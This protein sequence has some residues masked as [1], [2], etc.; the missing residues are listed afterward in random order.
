MN[1]I[2]SRVVDR[3]MVLDANEKERFLWE[4]GSDRCRSLLPKVVQALELR[5]RVTILVTVKTSLAL[6]HRVV[7]HPP[8]PRAPKR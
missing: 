3:R 7:R 6:L 5:L 4:R 2:V 1:H 8:A